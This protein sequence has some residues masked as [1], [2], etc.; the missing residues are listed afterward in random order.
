MKNKFFSKKNRVSDPIQADSSNSD[1]KVNL[2]IPNPIPILLSLVS[3]L[4]NFGIN[5]VNQQ[6]GLA[7][8]IA[9]FKT[10]WVVSY[11]LET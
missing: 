1:F 2:T 6:T 11:L 10:D 5:P 9:G 3:V 7:S 4:R 8:I